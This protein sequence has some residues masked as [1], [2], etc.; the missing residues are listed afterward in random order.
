MKRNVKEIKEIY[1]TL[2][3]EYDKIHFH[4]NSAAEYVE[5]RRLNLIYPYLQKSKGLRIL[6]VACGTGTYLAIGKR[7]GAEVFGCDISRNMTQICKDKGINNIFVADYHFL[8][9]KDN[10]FDLVLCINAIHYTNNVE[11]VISEM[12]RVL[13]DN[14]IILLTY[15]NILNFRSINYVRRIYKKNSQISY[16]HRYFPFQITKIL[17]KVKLTPTGHCGINLLPFTV[18]SKSRNKKILDICYEIEGHT[19]KTPLMHF[20]N[21]VFVVLKKNFKQINGE[22][23]W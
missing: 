7:M 4:P 21:E 16:Q 3:D 14:G 18:N 1:D 9:F 2:A 15:F 5:R 22:I 20:F 11:K 13:S 19:N 6:D 8:P 10:T 23:R 12:K 17:K